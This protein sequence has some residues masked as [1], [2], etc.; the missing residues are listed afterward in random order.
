MSRLGQMT[1]KVC[2]SIKLKQN[3]IFGWNSVPK[4]SEDDV[5]T[6]QEIIQHHRALEV[7]GII[8][9]WTP[10]C[11]RGEIGAQRDKGHRACD[12]QSSSGSP[13]LQIS[14][15]WLL[16]SAYKMT[17]LK[18]PEE[19]NSAYLFLFNKLPQTSG[20]NVNLSPPLVV[21]WFS[22]TQLGSSYV[23]SLWWKLNRDWDCGPLKTWLGWVS[24]VNTYVASGPCWLWAGSSAEAVTWTT[25]SRLSMLG[26]PHVVARF[27]EGA[28]QEEV[29]QKGRSMSLSIQ[30]AMTKYHKLV[31]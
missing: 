30:V 28:A 15:P 19:Q 31:S 5:H 27:P 9:T 10:Y 17:M 12:R 20:L 7:W 2:D 23:E 25:G 22:W 21:L 13:E 8:V 26:F 18:V 11:T 3:F 4:V 16:H 14:M 24:R 6:Y 29:F 1:L